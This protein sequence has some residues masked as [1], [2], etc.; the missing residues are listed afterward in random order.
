MYT[1][2]YV[3]HI[4]LYYC[5]RIASHSYV[6]K[7]KSIRNLFL[8]QCDFMVLHHT[9]CIETLFSVGAGNNKQTTCSDVSCCMRTQ[10]LDMQHLTLLPCVD[11]LRL[12]VQS[13][14]LQHTAAS[15]RFRPSEVESFGHKH[16]IF[17]CPQAL[18][19]K[20]T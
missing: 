6:D 5:T 12:P 16:C 15:N 4:T 1:Y 13:L 3:I 10:F 14:Q 8:A 7:P 20:S 2:I 9:K 17:P 19:K 11:G 18:K